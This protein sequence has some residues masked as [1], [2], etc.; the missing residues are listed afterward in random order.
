MC[1]TPDDAQRRLI[2]CIFAHLSE[3]SHAETTRILGSALG[4]LWCIWS[5]LRGLPL[6]LETCQELLG[7]SVSHTLRVS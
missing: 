3:C 1:D 5:S 2:V 7:D 4:E 6:I